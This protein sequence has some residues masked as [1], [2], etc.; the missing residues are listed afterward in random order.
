MIPGI[1]FPELKQIVRRR[2]ASINVFHKPNGSLSF[3]RMNNHVQR[4]ILVL[5]SMP[6]LVHFFQLNISQV[7][8]RLVVHLLDRASQPDPWCE[9]DNRPTSCRYGNQLHVFLVA[10]CSSEQPCCIPWHKLCIGEKVV[11]KFVHYRNSK[12]F[13][14]LASRVYLTSFVSIPHDNNLSEKGQT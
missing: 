13:S 11:M 10:F 6:R 8:Q 14:V 7:M 3:H 2:G 1:S 9:G 5:C 4:N 12:R